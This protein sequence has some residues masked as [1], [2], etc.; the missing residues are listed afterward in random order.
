MEWL[1]QFGNDREF[2]TLVWIAAGLVALVAFRKARKAITPTL[3]ILIGSSLIVL[4]AVFGA[5]LIAA[6]WL[7]H[8]IGF[9]TRGELWTTLLW[10]VFNGTV[11]FGTF[12]KAGKQPHFIRRRLVES[13]GATALV[14]AIANAHTFPLWVE[15]LILPALAFVAMLQAFAQSKQEHAQTKQEHAQI[16]AFLGWVLAGAG[17][18]L[19]VQSV[20]GFASSLGA[21]EIAGVSRSIAVPIWLSVA[22]APFIYVLGVYSAYQQMGILLDRG[23]SAGW[24][25]RLGLWSALRLRLEDVVGMNLFALRDAAE[26]GTYG[27]GRRAVAKFRADRAA[28]LAARRAASQRLADNAGLDGVD[29]EGRRLDRREFKETKAALE[30]LSV[31]MSGRFQSKGKFPKNVLSTFSGFDLHGLPESHGIVMRMSSDRWS[32]YAYRQTV[33]GWVFAV[34]AVGKPENAWWYDGPTPPTGPPTKP[35]WSD[36]GVATRPEWHGEAPT[37][38]SS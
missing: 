24:R 26:E 3:Q 11:W 32:W 5:W 19:V 17:V 38:S 8:S 1:R 22:S 15:L 21:D 20:L 36:I 33:T 27:A 31:C 37:L 9:W 4:V 6:V 29:D 35:D 28:D 10:F 34:G 16:A 30:W 2:A 13:I 23:G 12:S 25:A 7:A 18:V 14:E